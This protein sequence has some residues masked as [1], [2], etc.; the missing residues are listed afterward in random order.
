MQRRPSSS[1]AKVARQKRTVQSFSQFSQL[2]KD[3]NKYVRSLGRAFNRA[4]EI[5][6]RA[7]YFYGDDPDAKDALEV[8]KSAIE[9]V[10]YCEI[11]LQTN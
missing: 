7:D 1:P 6:L 2:I 8:R 10:A 9:F 11:L 4:Q 5:R 3:E